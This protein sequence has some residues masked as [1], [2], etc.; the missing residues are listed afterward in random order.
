MTEPASSII[1]NLPPLFASIAGMFT[2]FTSLLTAVASIYLLLAQNK[3]KE[4]V[5]SK[6]DLLLAKT[7]KEAHSEGYI[8]ANKD[9]AAQALGNQEV[10]S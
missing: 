4:N 8:D 9:S 6:M 7:A 5:N 10:K 3:L 1:I 2:A